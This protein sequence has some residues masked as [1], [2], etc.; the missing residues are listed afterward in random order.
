[1]IAI[2]G[3]TL[4]LIALTWGGFQFAWSSAHVLAPLILGFLLLVAFFV[5]EF[6]VPND[7]TVPLDTLSNWTSFS[8]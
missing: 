7:P 2:A 4:A 5:Y 1:M 6:F 8:G 3:T